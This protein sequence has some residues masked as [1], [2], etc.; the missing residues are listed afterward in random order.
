VLPKVKIMTEIKNKELKVQELNYFNY[1]NE[2]A[3]S[4]LYT[5]GCEID[6]LIDR[7]NLNKSV[8]EL[9]VFKWRDSLN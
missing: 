1:L 6:Y 7:F 3:K 5:I 9:L 2:Y 8:A 4:R